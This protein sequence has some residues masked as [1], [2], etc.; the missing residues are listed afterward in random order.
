MPD[1]L[2]ESIFYVSF[3]FQPPSK[4]GNYHYPH[5]TVWK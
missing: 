1:G 5:L 3:Y 4:T 2:L